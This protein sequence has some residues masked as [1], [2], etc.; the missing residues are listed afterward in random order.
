MWNLYGA[1]IAS[2]IATSMAS[3]LHPSTAL[4]TAGGGHSSA[5]PLA[6]AIV[7]DDSLVINRL[8]SFFLSLPGVHSRRTEARELPFPQLPL[9]L[10]GADDIQNAGTVVRHRSADVVGC[11]DHLGPSVVR[12]LLYIKYILV[13]VAESRLRWPRPWPRLATHAT[14]QE[15]CIHREAACLR[16]ILSRTL[17]TTE[18]P[19]SV[20]RQKEASRRQRRAL[21][22]HVVHKRLRHRQQRGRRLVLLLTSFL[23]STRRWSRGSSISVQLWHSYART[24]EIWTSMTVAARLV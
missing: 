19:K 6:R 15:G 14:A 9:V 5:S 11:R 18:R 4:R 8:R 10:A 2:D 24:A 12:K 1:V 23:G 7:V 13:Q 16:G 21:L 17:E 20:R 3:P 22:A